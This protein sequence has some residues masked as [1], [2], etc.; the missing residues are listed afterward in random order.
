M[1][2]KASV[3][4][5]TLQDAFPEGQVSLQPL[6]T[7]GDHYAC[8][9]ISERFRGVPRVRQHQMVYDAFGGRIGTELHAL[10]VKTAVPDATPDAS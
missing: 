10:A 1:P 2:M 5:K 9:V 6:A 8:T 4:L 7:D 3:V